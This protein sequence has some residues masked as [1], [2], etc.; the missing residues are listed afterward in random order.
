MALLGFRG[1]DDSI[2]LPRRHQ[3]SDSLSPCQTPKQALARGVS[4]LN[5]FGTFNRHAMFEAEVESPVQASTR[6]S[7]AR[8]LQP[9]EEPI[10]ADR[11]PGLL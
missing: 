11:V 9:L 3:V 1:H 8:L 10:S 4:P 5:P 7:V 2:E 6:G